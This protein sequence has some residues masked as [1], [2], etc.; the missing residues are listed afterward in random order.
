M[1]SMSARVKRVW[2]AEFRVDFRCG[3]DGLLAEAY[4]CELTPFEGD[5]LIFVGRDRRRIKVLYADSNGLW[6]CYKVFSRGTSK[7][8]FSFIAD[9]N[10]REI[11]LAELSLLLDGADYTV[12]RMQSH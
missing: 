5:A 11:S 3:H 10:C 12:H 4:A 6:V 7:T 9:R 8:L 2:L 1:L